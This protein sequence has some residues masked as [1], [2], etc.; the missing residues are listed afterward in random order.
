[1]L[2]G[3]LEELGPTRLGWTLQWKFEVE[4]WDVVGKSGVL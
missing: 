3:S 1:M 4:T 2:E